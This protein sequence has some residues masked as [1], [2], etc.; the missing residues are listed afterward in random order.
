MLT[1]GWSPAA[2]GNLLRL[3]RLLRLHPTRAKT[4][5]MGVKLELEPAASC[6]ASEGHQAAPPAANPSPQSG[7]A[8]RPISSSGS[9]IQSVEESANGFV[10]PSVNHFLHQ[11]P[12]RNQLVRRSVNTPLISWLVLAAACRPERRLTGSP[13]AAHSC[14]E[15]VYLD[16]RARSG[17]GGGWQVGALIKDVLLEEVS[18]TSETLVRGGQTVY[19]PK[20]FKLSTF[21]PFT[22]QLL[23]THKDVVHMQM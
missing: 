19:T 3:L 12:V 4:H 2:A 8:G 21:T 15:T 23:V 22:L 5:L 6:P 13:P 18:L 9:V 7:P 14:V 17:G 10:I 16:R 1:N 20:C 11:E